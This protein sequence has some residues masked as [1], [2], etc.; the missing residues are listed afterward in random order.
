M[1]E[2]H[3]ELVQRAARWLTHTRKSVVVVTECSAF[4]ANL[5]PDALGWTARGT[6]TLIEC[7]TSVSDFYRDRSKP[8]HRSGRLVGRER[9]YLT[10]RCEHGFLRSV[11]ACPECDKPT[12]QYKA[13]GITSEEMA[14]AVL[15]E[16]TITGAARA[17]QISILTIYKRAESCE[18]LH[19]ALE[20]RPTYQA[21]TA[22]R[23]V[24]SA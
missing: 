16:G 1:A 24:T 10:P 23:Q 11:A 15:A 12:Y 18:V 6:S 17:L 8:S 13:R 14:A 22:R 20:S 19:A 21:K 7:K 9:F 2:T 5:S 3:A 4:C